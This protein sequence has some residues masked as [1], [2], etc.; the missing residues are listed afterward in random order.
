MRVKITT[1]TIPDVKNLVRECEAKL[2][3][4]DSSDIFAVITAAKG[5]LGDI[6]NALCDLQ[7][8]DINVQMALIDYELAKKAE[9]LEDLIDK[10][11]S[12]PMATLLAY[13]TQSPEHWRE[14]YDEYIKLAG[15]A[16]TKDSPNG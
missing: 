8:T 1:T 11:T 7:M 4:V 6:G 10:A 2:R 16:N 13:A 15:A 9:I 5:A 3:A 14:S 12:N